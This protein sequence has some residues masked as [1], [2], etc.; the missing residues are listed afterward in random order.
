MDQDG[1]VSS[2]VERDNRCGPPLT[3]NRPVL[4]L[5]RP[6]DASRRFWAQLSPTFRN[7][8]DCIISPL[9]EI[10]PFPVAPQKGVQGTILTSAHAAAALRSA[11]VT[12]LPC[13]TVGD[14]TALAARTEGAEATACGGTA[15]ALVDHL[16]A[17]RPPGPLLH[18]RGTHSRGDVALRLTS[19]G[20]ETRD[21]IVYDQVLCNLSSE[22]TEALRDARPIIAP[23][24]SPRSAAQF[25]H[26]IERVGGDPLGISPVALSQNVEKEL[27]R[28]RWFTTAV[29]KAPNADAMVEMVQRIAEQVS[30]VE[31]P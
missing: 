27:C 6:R 29:C 5:T 18:L 8:M 19:M 10:V 13:Y 30:R 1:G 22:A 4:L 12:H 26:E 3:L 7:S 31:R 17:L 2:Y 20:I 9:I 21:M 25:A 15:D 24:F 14:A 11:E 28:Q 16:S 23:L